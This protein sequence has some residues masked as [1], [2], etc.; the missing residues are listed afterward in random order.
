MT[1]LI[2]FVLLVG[3]ACLIAYLLVDIA[4]AI[5]AKLRESDR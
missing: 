5:E 1:A 2:T 3:F 4:Q